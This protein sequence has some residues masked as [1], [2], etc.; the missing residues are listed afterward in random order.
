MVIKN[1]ALFQGTAKDCVLGSSATNKFV[2][3]VWT[4]GTMLVITS[5]HWVADV[6]ELSKEDQEWI[7]ENEVYVLCQNKLYE[8]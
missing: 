6:S 2:Y 3:S 7:H 8:D 4:Y 5:N 1:K